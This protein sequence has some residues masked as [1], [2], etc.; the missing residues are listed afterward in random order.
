M[1]APLGIRG[2]LHRLGTGLIA[3]GVLGLV[4]AAIGFAGLVW[5]NDR[6]G[7]LRAEVDTTLAQRAAT[8]RLAA[9]VLHDAATTTR[10]FSVTIDQSSQA[11]SSAA[12]T[13]TE[14][15]SDLEALEAQLRSVN[16]LGATPLSDAAAD[17]GRIAGSMDG[18]DARLSG[19]AASLGDNREALTANA[20][21][22]G[23]LA[24]MTDSLAIRLSSGVV[25][26]SLGDLQR[27][28]SV[29]LLVF[30][31]WSLVPAAGAL[32]LGAWLRRFSPTIG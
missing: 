10:S 16:I 14:V 31:A 18:L 4:V 15:R 2:G 26:D 7:S 32:V 25:E 23:Q 19:I 27:V 22:L 1:T 13:I 9:R 8:M 29:T 17:F 20:S 5:V 24:D 12:G 30:S 28:I 21:S 11:V 6:V 3:F